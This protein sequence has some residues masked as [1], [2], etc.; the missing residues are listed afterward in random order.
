M[1]DSL[2]TKEIPRTVGGC[3]S[4]IKFC[5]Q[6]SGLEGLGD[7]RVLLCGVTGLNPCQLVA[8]PDMVLED[9]E[10][11]SIKKAM[12]RHLNHES[13]HRILG[14]CGFYNLKLEISPYTFEPR[15]E[16]ELLV[17]AVL[18]HVVNFSDRKSGM[19][20]LDLGTGT[21][22]VCLALL[23]ECSDFKGIGVDVSCKA[24]EVAR[25]NASINGLGRRF[26]TIQSN[27]FSFV[28]GFFDVIVSNPPYIASAVVDGLDSRVKDFDPRISLDGGADGLS[29][30]RILADGVRR[31]LSKNGICCIE[32]GYDQKKD[33]VRI[34]EK[35]KLFL[36]KYVKDY[37][38]NDRVLL[39][40]R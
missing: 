7:P 35:K 13:I 19:R 29:H 38:D 40:C 11:L 12:F 30:Y 31:H 20:I 33:V 32:I 22:A 18:S 26:L 4:F 37:G 9:M 36:L 28:K 16:T 27:W 21:G 23:K 5:F 14:W 25:K 8:F 15:P 3:L 2:L 17:S 34:F 1:S 10:L 24:L 6:D 39:F